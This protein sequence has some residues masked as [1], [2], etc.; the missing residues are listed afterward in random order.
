MVFKNHNPQPVT[1]RWNNPDSKPTTINPG[2]AFM[3]RDIRYSPK[4]PDAIGFK[5]YEGDDNERPISLNGKTQFEIKPTQKDDL[6]TN[7]FVINPGKL[8]LI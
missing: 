7:E 8:N 3:F 4:K 1:I 2:D 6:K 5:V